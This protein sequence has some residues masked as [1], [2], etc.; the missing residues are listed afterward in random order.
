MIEL[1]QLT[2]DQIIDYKRGLINRR[3]DWLRRQHK[4][5]PR[6]HYCK[7]VT[8]IEPNGRSSVSYKIGESFFATLDHAVPQSRGGLDIA[9]NYRLACVTCNALK[10]DMSEKDFIA[11]LVRE[12]VR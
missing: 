11:E 6:C 3:R 2:V 8:T 7:I 9:S 12:G 4:K 10:G 1:Q 5:N